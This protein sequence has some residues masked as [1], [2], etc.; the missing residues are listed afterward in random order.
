MVEWDE[1][2]KKLK[3]MSRDQLE[4]EWNKI[5]A[6]DEEA[7]SRKRMFQV[8]QKY[9]CPKCK[10]MME[11]NVERYKFDPAIRSEDLTEESSNLWQCPECK[12]VILVK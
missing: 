11:H 1:Y 6:K 8:Y 5:V 7:Y 3:N 10:T 9:K 2:M 4:N 12:F